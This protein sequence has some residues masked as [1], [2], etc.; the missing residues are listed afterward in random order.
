M[1]GEVVFRPPRGPLHPPNVLL[2]RRPLLLPVGEGALPRGRAQ[3]AQGPRQE[4]HLQHGSVQQT[5]KQ[6]KNRNLQPPKEN[7]KNLNCNP[8]GASL[9]PPRPGYDDH[10]LQSM[11]RLCSGWR[12]SCQ[13]GLKQAQNTCL[14]PSS[15]SSS[16]Y[17]A[18]LCSTMNMN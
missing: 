7:S 12:Q 2:R 3:R 16:F 17:S 10:N 13:R 6:T 14:S 18:S 9:F 11:N 15:T 4:V 1:R 5:N 8:K